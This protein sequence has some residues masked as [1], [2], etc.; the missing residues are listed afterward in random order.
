MCCMLLG[1]TI[2]EFIQLREKQKKKTFSK[3]WEIKTFIWKV[4]KSNCGRRGGNKHKENNF[5]TQYTQ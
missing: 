4:I 5:Y 2:F 1:C 3:Y